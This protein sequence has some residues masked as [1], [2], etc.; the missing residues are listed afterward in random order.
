M[1]TTTKR[2]LVVD[3][4]KDAA[5]SLGFL[6]ATA[7][8]DVETCLD[9][10]TALNVIDRFHPDACLLD[11]NM[12]GMD[13]YE[14]ARLIVEKSPDDPPLLGAVTG[15]DDYLHLRQA[16][17]AGFDLHFTKSANPDELLEQLGVSIRPRTAPPE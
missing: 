12:P 11:I 17:D 14:L 9:G 3:D 4:N 13:G 15:Y 8:F 10:E 1:K 5:E 16:V 6:L 2:I 7:G